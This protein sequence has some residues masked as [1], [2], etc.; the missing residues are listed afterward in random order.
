MEIGIDDANR[1]VLTTGHKSI[2]QPRELDFSDFPT[3]LTTITESQT[4]K[5]WSY[6]VGASNGIY[7]IQRYNDFGGYF[8]LHGA[9]QRNDVILRV[10]NR[11]NIKGARLSVGLRYQVYLSYDNDYAHGMFK[12]L[13]VTPDGSVLATLFSRNTDDKNYGYGFNYLDIFWVG[14]TCKVAII[15]SRQDE[16]WNNY[17]E[18]NTYTITNSDVR[19]EFYL[20]AG[21]NSNGT[22]DISG[23]VESVLLG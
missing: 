4:Y 7:K 19:L 10:R 2:I 6:I 15:Y 17:Q 20:Y 8:T 13:L 9:S 12:T 14:D 11:R 3:T 23:W 22:I 21:S 1:L 5:H 16:T 18:Y